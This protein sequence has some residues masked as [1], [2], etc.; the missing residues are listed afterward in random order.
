MSLLITTI[1]VLFAIYAPTIYE[2]LVIIITS[3][4]LVFYIGTIVIINIIIYK[5]L[6]K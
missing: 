4:G 6:G 3:D 2:V 1:I 5:I